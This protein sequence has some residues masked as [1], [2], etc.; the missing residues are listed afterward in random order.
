MAGALEGGDLPSR[1][2]AGCWEGRGLRASPWALRGPTTP[3]SACEWLGGTA[4]LCVPPIS[5]C[6]LTGQLR[7]PHVAVWTGLGPVV[8]AASPHRTSS[9]R[10]LTS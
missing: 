2:R 5:S 4:G 9:A 6:G 3:S 8:T 10:W 7:T 1:G